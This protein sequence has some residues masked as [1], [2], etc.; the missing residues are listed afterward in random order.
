MNFINSFSHFFKLSVCGGQY[1][2]LKESNRRYDYTSS[3]SYCDQSLSGWYRFG[4]SAG[5]QMV[6]GCVKYGDKRCG[7]VAPGHLTGGHSGV[8]DGIVERTVCFSLNKNCCWRR[9]TIKVLNCGSFYVYKINGTPGCN[10][11]YCST[12]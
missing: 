7:T 4:G 5:T 8:N 1:N 2:W 12:G 11:R 3:W 6:T 9:R 10:Y